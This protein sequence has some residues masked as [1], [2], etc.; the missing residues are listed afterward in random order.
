MCLVPMA[1][2]ISLVDDMMLLAPVLFMVIVGQNLSNSMN[3]VHYYKGMRWV[4]LLPRMGY[5]CFLLSRFGATI[6]SISGLGIIGYLGAI[7]CMIVDV[8]FGD[9]VALRS[10]GLYCRY[11]VITACPQRVFV[12][13]RVGAA[14]IEEAF[15]HRGVV[16]EKVSGFPTWEKHHTLIADIQGMLV[17]LRPITKAEWETLYDQ[18][19]VFSEPLSFLALDLYNKK[20]PDWRGICEKLEL[21]RR[22]RESMRELAAASS[23]R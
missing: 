8:V 20:T 18:N 4:T 16:N 15:G 2:L 1:M 3:S 7:A 22:A 14:W 6:G 23:Y 17:E 12:C 5:Y 19:V 9:L 13:R 10:I 21:A 11:E